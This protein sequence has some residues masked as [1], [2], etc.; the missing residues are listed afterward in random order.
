MSENI[1]QLEIKALTSGYGEIQVLWGIDVGI[2]AGET[3]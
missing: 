3:V 1:A 2:S